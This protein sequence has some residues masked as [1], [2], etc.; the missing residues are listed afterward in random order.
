[1]MFA[2]FW[3][4]PAQ[5]IGKKTATDECHFEQAGSAQ[6]VEHMTNIGVALLKAA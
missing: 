3:L 2:E 1:M 5:Q 6:V 4:R